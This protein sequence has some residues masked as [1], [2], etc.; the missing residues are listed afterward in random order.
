MLQHKWLKL[1]PTLHKR[2]KDQLYENILQGFFS[3][4]NL[5]PAK[6]L[7]ILQRPPQYNVRYVVCFYVPNNA[8]CF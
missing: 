4:A 1:K 8:E 7:R 6:T 3:N 5:S 2:F